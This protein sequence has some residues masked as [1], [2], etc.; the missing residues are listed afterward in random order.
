MGKENGANTTAASKVKPELK[1]VDLIDSDDDCAVVECSLAIP[2]DQIAKKEASLKKEIKAE[3]PKRKVGKKV[4]VK[5]E[6]KKEDGDQAKAR[7]RSRP[8]EKAKKEKKKPDK[9]KSDSSSSESSE[10]ELSEDALYKVIKP[11]T[12]VMIVNLIR[13]AELNGAT[14]QVI[15]PSVAVCPCP[16]GCVLVR[17]DT[18]REIA[19]K[20][21][22]LQILNSFQKGLHCA[23]NSE[24]LR[25]V[26]KTMK[27]GAE[28]AMGGKGDSVSHSILGPT[29][30][31]GGAGHAL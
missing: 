31:Q 18:G 22:N 26:L 10:E 2:A 17:L 27:E 9:G 11:Y 29:S 12:K 15:H 19:V 23:S 1:T 3:L 30:S 4:K 24:R 13:K 6:K 25:Q 20:P 28:T 8:K 16:P 5:K 21:P 14:G 7:S